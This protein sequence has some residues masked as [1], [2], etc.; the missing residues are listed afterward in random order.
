MLRIL[1][2]GC[3]CLSLVGCVGSRVDRLPK[4]TKFRDVQ[5]A[6]DI[7]GIFRNQ[8]FSHSGEWQPLLSDS[9]FPE[10]TFSA[11]PCEVR[12]V[13]QSPSI[14]RIEAMSQGNVLAVRD[15][16]LGQDFHI[17]DG[18]VKLDRKPGEL[19]LSGAGVGVGTESSVIRLTDSGDVVL[20][21]RGGGVGMMLFIVPMAV[22]EAQDA[23]FE[24]IKDGKYPADGSDTR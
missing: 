6:S 16:V 21:Q 12:I 22:S 11:P 17:V 23:V 7:V 1:L 10:I 24:R 19:L 5:S 2:I 20:A 9:F 14:L 3:I 13:S 15:L 8:G 18:S 4:E